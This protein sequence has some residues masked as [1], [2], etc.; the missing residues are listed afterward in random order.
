MGSRSSA[1]FKPDLS[2]TKTMTIRFATPEDVPALVQLGKHMH[3]ITRFRKLDYNEARVA[4]T[5]TLALTQGKERYV[6]LI[7]ND[8]QNTVA[9][10]LLAVLETHIFSRQLIASIMHYDVLPQKR[11]GGY[12]V[13][14]LKAFEQWCK[15]R[16]VAEI[17]FGINS[18]E[19]L[20]EMQRLGSFAV[21]MG[22]LKVGE[23]YVQVL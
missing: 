16:Q 4:Q 23:N 7:A 17:N 20:Q 19:E 6:C 8:S 22:Y 14:L 12:G 18:V 15:N 21:R 3:A 11:M 2:S 13:R 5:L 1:S 10:V 9:G